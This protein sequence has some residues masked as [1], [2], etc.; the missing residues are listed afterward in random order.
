MH[1]VNG[2]NTDYKISAHQTSVAKKN[3]PY[4]HTTEN[5]NSA[6]VYFLCGGIVTKWENLLCSTENGTVV[7]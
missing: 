7:R 6:N 2:V 4:L 3:Y 5:N 1:V